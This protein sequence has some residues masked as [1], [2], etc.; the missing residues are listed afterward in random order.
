MEHKNTMDRDGD[1]DTATAA[2]S[3][4]GETAFQTEDGVDADETIAEAPADGGGSVGE[5]EEEEVSENEDD[6]DGDVSAADNEDDSDD[7]KEAQH[8][9]GE[10]PEP[11][12]ALL[13]GRFV[14]SKSGEADAVSV[15]ITTFPA[16]LG[17]THDKPPRSFFGLGAA[18]SL[19]RKHFV[20]YYRDG[21][22]GRLQYSDEGG[23][24]GEGGDG[25]GGLVYSPVAQV[26]RQGGNV[27]GV[28]ALIHGGKEGAPPSAG[29]FALECLGK[30]KIFVGGSRIEQG[31]AAVLEHMTTVKLT[32]YNLYFLLPDAPGTVMQVPNPKYAAYQRKRAREEAKTKAQAERKAKKA[33]GSLSPSPKQK[34]PQ[35]LSGQAKIIADFEALTTA[36]L[37]QKTADAAS[38]PNAW[39]RRHQLLNSAIAAHAVK[40]AARD[41][42]IMA[43]HAENG[44][45]QRNDVLEWIQQSSTFQGW[46]EL[47]LKKL[48]KKS[49]EKN[50]SNAILRAGYTRSGSTGRHVRWT[51]PQGLEEA[52]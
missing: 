3:G 17:R 52:G 40:A 2:T 25:S 10:I 16:T 7:G 5:V 39:D 21:A 35:E 18:K 14:D 41:Q 50:I 36:E 34:K 46:V 11:A 43:I 44:G 24:E 6:G 20:I 1:E 22:G 26:Q 49:Y 28:K 31:E 45:I 51:L 29:F 23:G 12:Y 38:A 9:G 13:S 27:D 4:A 30:N 8:V 33:K 15:P 37:L 48:E 47:M 42:G 32:N 19:S